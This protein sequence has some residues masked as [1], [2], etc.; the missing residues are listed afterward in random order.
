MAADILGECGL[1]ESREI[2]QLLAQM[3]DMALEIATLKMKVKELESK[4]PIDLK[5]CINKQITIPV[6]FTGFYN[7]DLIKI[8][9]PYHH[10][11]GY[12]V[13]CKQDLLHMIEKYGFDE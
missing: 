1:S 12:T 9:L 10:M 6:V 5:E 4:Q 13:I 7:D 3:S 2:G 11:E 8:R